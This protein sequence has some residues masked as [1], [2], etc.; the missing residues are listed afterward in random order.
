MKDQQEYKQLERQYGLIEKEKILYCTG[1]LGD[2]ELDSE[3]KEPIVLPRRHKFTELVITECHKSVMH[4]GI[5]STLAQFRSKYWIS[6]GRQEVKRLLNRCLICKRW[7]CKSYAKPQQAALP[8]FR[9][10]RA[11]PFENSGVDFAG[12]LF[13]KTKGGMSKVYIALFTCCV[14]RAVHLEL[15]QDLTAATFL[16]A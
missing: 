9:A 5:R 11:A 13:A 12:P 7:K 15:V 2:S 6:K 16:G 10:K 4:C 14:T 1:R 3:A 8:A